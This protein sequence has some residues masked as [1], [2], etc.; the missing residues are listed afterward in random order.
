MRKLRTIS[1]V[2]V[3]GV[4]GLAVVASAPGT[5]PRSDNASPRRLAAPPASVSSRY[6]VAGNGPVLRVR[7]TV[8][9]GGVSRLGVPTGSAVVVSTPTGNQ[10][11]IR[12]RVAGGSVQAAIPDGTGGWYIGGTFTS[13]GGV[14]R[15]GLAHLSTGGTLD[16]AFAPPNLGQVRALALDAG[17]L[18]VG[19]VQ[20]LSADPWFLPVLSALDPA[21]GALLPVSYPVVAHTDESPVFGVIALAAGDGRLYVAFNGDNGIAAYDESNGALVWSEPGAQSYGEYSGPAALALA[22]G[23]LLAGGQISASGGPVNLEELDPA[24]GALMARPAIDG[25]VAG[26]ATVGDIAYV[27][28]RSPRVVG[29]NVWKLSLV[30]G[31]VARLAVVKGATAIAAN[32]T[33]LYVTGQVAVGGN[34]RVYALDVG[35]AKPKPKALPPV[36]VGGGVSVLAAQSGRLL[37]A[38]S[39]LGTGGIKRAGLAAFDAATGSLLPWRPRVAGGDVRALASAGKTIYLA[40]AFTGVSGHPRLGLAA[41]SALGRGKLLPWRPRLYQGHFGSLV[42]AQGRVYA[43][44]SAKPHGANA[45]TPLRHLL[46]FSATTARPLRFKSRIGHVHL[47]ALGNHLVIAES[48]CNASGVTSACISAFR[49]GG[50]GQA[51]WRRSIQGTVYA[52]QTKASTLYVGGQFSSFGEQPRTNLAALALNQSGTL[53]DFAPPIWLPVTALAPTDYGLV[54]AT[55]AFGAGSSGPYFVGAQALGAVAANGAVL[56]WRMT[57]PPNDVPLSPSDT[58]AVSGNF[59]VGHLEPVPGGFV[60]R[61]NFSWIGPADDPAPGSLAWLR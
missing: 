58:A 61:G 10:Q 36:L 43:G 34:V 18:Y 26:I 12:A 28:A 46:V 15:P 59:A 17:R 5:T 47:M 14:G 41:V 55:S 9:V 45:S 11:P 53:L 54:F 24:T 38:G 60:A 31:A 50:G 13:V 8:Y 27:L 48:T 23:R 40:G 7:N 39:F 42:V 49:V 22:D 20:A 44:G 3:V 21:T 19:G 30:S 4:C 56:P 51:L 33:S 2:L 35:Q 16:A 32:G 52:L 6:V 57:F 29:L 25:Q 37:I 1:L